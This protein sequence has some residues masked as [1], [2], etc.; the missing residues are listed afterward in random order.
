MSFLKGSVFLILVVINTLFWVPILLV[1]ALI[2][3]IVP[4]H[5]FRRAVSRLLVWIAETWVALNTHSH[6]ILHGKKLE[7]SGLNDLQK[8]DWYLLISNHVAAA[9]IPVLQS[10]FHK[11]IPF[12][13]FF[14]KKELIWM[15]FLGLAWWALDFPFMRR[16]TKEYL[17]KNPHMKGKDLEITRKACEKF[18]DYPITVINYVEGTRFTQVK[19]DKQQSPFTHL[20]K[21][22]SGG[23]GFVLGSMGDR[24][25]YLILTSIK[26]LPHPPSPWEYMCGKF[27]KVQV[28]VEKIKIPDNLKNKNYLTDSAFKQDLQSWL[29][30]LWFKQDKKLS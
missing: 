1:F 19:H 14:L 17:Q 2:K 6:R 20:L 23:I 30:E 4:I 7:V 10:V 22:K 15:P 11:K 12:L 13:K 25:S 3:L 29:N 16:F 28:L 9:D 26:Y 21:P 18:R 27:A 5:A 8:D 24:I